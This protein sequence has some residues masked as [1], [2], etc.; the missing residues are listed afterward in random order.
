MTFFRR[1]WFFVG[2]AVVIMLAF[3]CPKWG[4]TVRQSRVVNIGIFFS[5]LITGAS[6]NL[7]RAGSRA[8]HAGAV[9]AAT[10]SALLLIPVMAWLLV[11]AI[12]SKTPDWV[13]GTTLIA[14]APVT[15]ASGTILTAMAQGDVALS[16]MICMAT[17]VI[18]L[19]TMPF[20]FSLLLGAGP[21]IQMPVLRLLGGLLLT[22]LVPVAIGWGM[23]SRIRPWLGYWTRP[24]GQVVVLFI[25][26]NAASSSARRF[27]FT[28]D[29]GYL[30]IFIVA[31][32]IG[33]LAIHY[34]LARGLRL[35]AASVS[36]F[37]IH[38]SQ[39]T[40]TVSYLVWDGYLAVAYPLAMLPGIVYHLTQMVVDTF[41]A[42][43]FRRC[44]KPT[45]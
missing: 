32:H 24:F 9:L 19:F 4:Q 5:F 41:V 39:K 12:L 20:V 16:L 8:R 11:R 13:I 44:A 43:A 1:H 14:S 36:A 26:F 23:R 37:T 30:G 33:I 15:I 17:N 40:L 38:A 34:A 45:C 29:F 6:L 2:L 31:M 22:V 28:A 3:A 21:Q 25:I 27:S 10:L 35:D 7:P 18:G 42:G